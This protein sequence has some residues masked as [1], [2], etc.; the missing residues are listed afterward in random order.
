MPEPMR[1][2]FLLVDTAISRTARLALVH[3]D[4][5][6][7]RGHSVRIVTPGLPLTWRSSRAD[8][9]YV[10]DFREYDDSTDDAVLDGAALAALPVAVEDDLFRDATPAPHAP[11]R[12][13]LSGP[14]ER[15]DGGIAR[16]YGAIA[17]ARWF[18]QSLDLVRVSP[19]AP[20]REE[21]LEAVQEFHVGLSTAE[22]ARLVHSC[23]VLV[24]PTLREEVPSLVAAEG[25]A[26]GLACVFT[27]ISGYLDF[28]P[29]H[30][31]ARFAPEANAVEL[32]ERL[33]ELLGDA[34]LM[35]RVRR[36][37]REVAEQFRV[38]RLVA[39]VEERLRPGRR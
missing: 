31:Y 2:A 13:L 29:Q 9:V 33:I 16:G 35:S 1:I 15:E 8:W 27:G 21:P 36:R 12:V 18:H 30:D 3:A 37:G 7:A 10:D 20:S 24:V 19:W 14:W 34:D 25:M 32:G 4:A 6:I 28:D 23:D 17:H 22:M 26:A 11:P 5:L 39:G 38:E